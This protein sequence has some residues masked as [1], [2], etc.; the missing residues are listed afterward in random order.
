[1][2]GEKSQHGHYLIQ[3]QYRRDR[4]LYF[5]FSRKAIR[6]V[7][8]LEIA[9][10]VGMTLP[11]GTHNAGWCASVYLVSSTVFDKTLGTESRTSV[12]LNH[13][14]SV[15][16]NISWPHV[17]AYSRYSHI[18]LFHIKCFCQGYSSFLHSDLFLNTWQPACG[19]NI[20]KDGR[21][22]YV[23]LYIF[24]RL[25]LLKPA[26]LWNCYQFSEQ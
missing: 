14:T 18:S 4:A 5:L 8:M 10:V 21:R 7:W 17:R 1:M 6:T 2:A 23:H 16:S 26:R 13:S 22:K 25:P 12:H 24:R 3:I 9:L 15:I 19:K 11:Y 20:T